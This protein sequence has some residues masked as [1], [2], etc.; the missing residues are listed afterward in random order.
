MYVG[1]AG[2]DEMYELEYQIKKYENSINFL[3]SKKFYKKIKSDKFKNTYKNFKYSLN[4]LLKEPKY[5][6]VIREICVKDDNVNDIEFYNSDHYDYIEKYKK[7]AI[8]LLEII[9]T[10]KKFDIIN[11]F[12]YILLKYIG[13]RINNIWKTDEI[14]INMYENEFIDIPTCKEVEYFFLMLEI[15]FIKIENFNLNKK[16]LIEILDNDEYMNL[17]SELKDK[18]NPILYSN[19]K[20][21]QDENW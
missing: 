17:L 19:Y 14:F 8:K 18:L 7:F 9:K 13:K 15:I 20:C 11:N 1:T 6:V 2:Q 16:N 12:E 3:T 4:S 10:A 21:D 5:F